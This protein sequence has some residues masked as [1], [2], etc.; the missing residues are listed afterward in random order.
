MITMSFS[1]LSSGLGY[2]LQPQTSELT[3]VPCGN[4]RIST[5]SPS[6]P[7]HI[8]QLG[9]S[10]DQLDRERDSDVGISNGLEASRVWQV[11]PLN[12]LSP[13]S[14]ISYYISLHFSFPHSPPLSRRSSVMWRRSTRRRWCPVLSSTMRRQLSSF[15]WRASGT[16]QRSLS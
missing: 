8:L 14:I 16:G 13:L 2:Q 12:P 10:R 1:S 11:R 6:L 7:P 4:L 15:R 5:L 3:I 9:G